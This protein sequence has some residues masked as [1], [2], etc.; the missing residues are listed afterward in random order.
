M[1]PTI[2]WASWRRLRRG[3]MRLR[4][5]R[6]ER[7]EIRDRPIHGVTPFP[8]FA[9]AQPGLRATGLEGVID[10]G[11]A[12]RDTAAPHLILPIPSGRAPPSREY[13]AMLHVELGKIIDEAFEKRN[14]LSPA[15][16]GPVRDAVDEALDL[17]DRGT[18]RVAERRGDGT[19]HVN[20]WLKKAVLMSF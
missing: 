16:K 17:L 11:P 15:T 6:I 7:S 12:V 1:L 19:W 18:A 14:D 13:F 5:A 2:W 4:V 9:A 10:I 8:R 20:Q 3:A